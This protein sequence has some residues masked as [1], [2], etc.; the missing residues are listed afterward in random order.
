[1]PAKGNERSLGEESTEDGQSGQVVR[2]GGTVSLGA[3]PPVLHRTEPDDEGWPDG[4]KRQ[5]RSPRASGTQRRLQLS[6]YWEQHSESFDLGS[7]RGGR[8]QRF[9]FMFIM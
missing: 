6:S 3:Q 8:D 5:G 9:A 1:M 7:E 2:S 4:G